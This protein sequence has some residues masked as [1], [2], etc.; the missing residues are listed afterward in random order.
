MNFIKLYA[1]EYDPGVTLVS[2][3]FIDYFLNAANDCQ[4]KI[5]LYLVRHISNHKP[6]TISNIADEFNY[7]ESDILRA[8]NYWEQK[9]VLSTEYDGDN[10]LI[11]IELHE[12]NEELVRP[13]AQVQLFAMPSLNDNKNNKSTTDTKT[14]DFSNEELIALSKD[15]E[16]SAVKTLAE[17]YFSR[18]ISATDIQ[19]LAYIYKTLGYTINEVDK[20][21]EECLSDGKKTMRSIRKVAEDRFASKT[22]DPSVKE[23]LDALGEK[24]SPTAE[25]IDYANRWLSMM[26]LDLILEGCKKACMATNT[27]RFQYA[28]G[29][30]RNWKKDN[31]RTIADMAASEEAFRKNKEA[32]KKPSVNREATG[33]KFK[34]YKQ[35]AYDFDALTREI[36]IN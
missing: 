12:V 2:N 36:R 13:A 22:F 9:Q 4:I 8:L 24:G 21:I 33:N 1:E 17:S 28:E 27:N 18:T 29:I 30:F 16:W 25:M 10:N 15:P 14:K 23:I 19:H 26:E 3:V 32:L 7:T 34:Q 5:Y 6:F 20:L 31:I 11:G 35:T